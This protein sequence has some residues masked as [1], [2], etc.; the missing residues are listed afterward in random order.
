MSEKGTHKITVKAVG[1]GA[2][3]LKNSEASNE[4]EVTVADA[5]ESTGS[6][7]SGNIE[8]SGSSGGCGSS[9]SLGFAGIAALLAAA[10]V[11]KKRK[12]DN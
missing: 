7:D 10:V 6:S 8:D 1:S 3:V 4:I 11:M 2:W 12:S 9:V 5:G